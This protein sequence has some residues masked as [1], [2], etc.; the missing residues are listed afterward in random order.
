MTEK[1][2]QGKTAPPNMIL[3]IYKLNIIQTKKSEK[4]Y[5]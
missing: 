4:E 1:Y 2:L 3:P 5:Q